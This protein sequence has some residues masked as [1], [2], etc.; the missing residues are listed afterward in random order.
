[1]QTETVAIVPMTCLL[2]WSA[3]GLFPVAPE[4]TDLNQEASSEGHI[5]IIVIIDPFIVHQATA[6]ADGAQQQNNTQIYICIY[7]CIFL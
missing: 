4:W 1:M 7:R 6:E 3:G 2:G 5:Y